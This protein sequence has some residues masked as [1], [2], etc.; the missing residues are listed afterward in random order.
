MLPLCTS[1]TFLRPFSSAY[2]MALRTRRCVPVMEMGLMPMPESSRICFGP[3]LSI[4]LLRNSMSLAT[5]GVHVF[6]VLAVDHDVHALGVLHRRG[7]AVVLHRANAGVQVE[8]LAQ[9]HVQR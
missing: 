8:D 2:W 5:S 9:R 7:R 3:P 4:S 6:R 1:V